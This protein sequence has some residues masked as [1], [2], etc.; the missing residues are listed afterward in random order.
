MKKSS[1]EKNR[2]KKIQKKN[3]RRKAFEKVKNIQKNNVPFTRITFKQPILSAKKRMVETSPFSRKLKTIFS[4][5]EN[6]LVIY[7]K[8]GEKEVTKTYGRREPKHLRMPE[9]MVI[10][11][12]R[13]ELKKQK[14]G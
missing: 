12:K 14:T 2:I 13:R 9:K 3:A 10:K 5:G 1:V 11:L 7:E 6:G 8:T 4:R